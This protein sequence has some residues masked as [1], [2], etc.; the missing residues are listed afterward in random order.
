MIGIWADRG[1]A[2]TQ[3][4]RNVSHVAQALPNPTLSLEEDDEPV[5]GDGLIGCLS[6]RKGRGG[7]TQVCVVVEV[8][9]EGD[10]KRIKVG[11]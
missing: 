4:V 7:Y 8:A 10:L 5:S 11:G 6:S 2:R 9:R 3:T 1:S